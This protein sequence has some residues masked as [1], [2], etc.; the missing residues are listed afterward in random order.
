M[1]GHPGLQHRQVHVVPPVQWQIRHGLLVHDIAQGATRGIHQRRF[2]VDRHFLLGR[3]PD[4]QYWIHD[5]FLRDFESQAALRL[6]LEPGQFNSHGVTA[7]RQCGCA[8]RAVLAGNY[9]ARQVCLL[10]DDR[11]AHTGYDRTRGVFHDS[12]NRAHVLL[13][14]TGNG[15]HQQESCGGGDQ[16]STCGRMFP[17]LAFHTPLRSCS[18]HPWWLG[19]RSLAPRNLNE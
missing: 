15:K 16:C 7:N 2:T 12:E 4:L 10:I 5:Q 14:Y 9:R 11:D 17:C 13:R 3:C 19:G 8:K 6:R 18:G 1:L